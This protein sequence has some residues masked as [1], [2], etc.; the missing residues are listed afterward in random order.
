M[1]RDKGG[2]IR[3]LTK[4]EF[5]RLLDQLPEHLRDM[6]VL[7]VA[8]GLRQSNVTKLQWRQI[9]LERRHL[10]VAGEDHKNGKAHSVPL[11]EAAMQVL[12]KR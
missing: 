10:W 7:S 12:Q 11:N 6:A 1:L 4:E 3:S 5:A 9:S 8:T 2:C